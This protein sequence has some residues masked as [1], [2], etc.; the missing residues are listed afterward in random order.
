LGYIDFSNKHNDTNN[1]STSEEQQVKK[2]LHSKYIIDDDIN[3]KMKASILYDLII[4]S[5]VV[6]ID[7]DKI[8]GFRTRLSKYLKEIGLHKKRYNDGFYYYGIIK[9]TPNEFNINEPKINIINEF[10]R[11]LNEYKIPLSELSEIHCKQ[12]CDKE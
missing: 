12:S 6:K 3:H 10:E 2:F 11:R 1:I 4:N 7:N 9:K 5:N 8:S